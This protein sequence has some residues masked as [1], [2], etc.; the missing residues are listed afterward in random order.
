MGQSLLPTDSIIA[1]ICLQH[2][3]Q[4]YK[5]VL[6]SYTLNKYLNSL[7]LELRNFIFIVSM[8]LLEPALERLN[9]L[10]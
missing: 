6:A 3:I 8:P 9:E 1:Y 7:K 5:I 2:F 10:I 4:T